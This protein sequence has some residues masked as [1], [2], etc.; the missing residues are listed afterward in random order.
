LIHETGSAQMEI[1]FMH[2]DA[3]KAA[4]HVFMFKRIMREAAM[5]HNIYATFMAKPMQREPGS[6][7]HF[8]QSL[9]DSKTGKNVFSNEDGTESELFFSYIAG[10]QK[11]T[12]ALMPFFAP[13][14]NS[15]RRIAP[16]ISSPTSLNWGYDNRTV[17]L[18]VPLSGPEAKR[19]E[20]RYPGADA[21]PY[22]AIAATLTAGLLGMK[23]GL[24][25]TDPYLGNAYEEPVD[26]PRSLEEALRL[27]DECEAVKDVIG[28]RFCRAYHSVKMTEY[29]AF[30]Q[31]ISSWER[32][33]LLLSV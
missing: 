24:K 21:N 11:Y 9:V 3:L 14:V 1:N 6:A 7:L 23:E 31:V 12:P 15:Y 30:Q 22:L 28:K 16:E 27:L 20:N 4:D 8:H 17:G 33:Y 2:G 10:L 19:I 29:E 32:E 18:R 25:P 26:L 13:S 5:R